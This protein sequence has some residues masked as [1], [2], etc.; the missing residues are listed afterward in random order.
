MCVPINTTCTT[1]ST[2]KE[3]TLQGKSSKRE[4]EGRRWVKS[5]A[6]LSLQKERRGISGAEWGREV[7]KVPRGVV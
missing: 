6:L 1:K 7:L 2:E 4:S 3:L 5:G